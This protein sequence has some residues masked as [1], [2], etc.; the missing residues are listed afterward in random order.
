MKARLSRLRIL[1]NYLSE[2]SLGLPHLVCDL[3]PLEFNDDETFLV[4]RAKR[5][6]SISFS[7]RK[8]VASALV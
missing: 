1:K 8:V 4:V 5:V 3:C 2:L 6:S 7:A